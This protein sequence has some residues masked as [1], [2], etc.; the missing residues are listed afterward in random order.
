MHYPGFDNGR[1][2]HSKPGYAI[3]KQALEERS[4]C[5]SKSALLPLAR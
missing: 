4:G 1:K 2:T 5:L 3:A